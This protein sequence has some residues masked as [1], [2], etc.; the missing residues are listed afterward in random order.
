VEIRTTGCL[1]LG[2]EEPP[3]S[4]PP[5]RL[6]PPPVTAFG[7]GVLDSSSTVAGDGR[8]TRAVVTEVIGLLEVA[9]RRLDSYLGERFFP[10]ADVAEIGPPDDDRSDFSRI[11]MSFSSSGSSPPMSWLC[12]RPCFCIRIHIRHPFHYQ[13]QLMKP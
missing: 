2:P 5:P 3:L 10:D 13:F 1:L 6:I 11:C 12:V 9:L 4:P 8:V 7:E